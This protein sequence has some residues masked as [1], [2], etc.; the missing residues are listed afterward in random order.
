M[1]KVYTVT[2]SGLKHKK[3]KHPVVDETTRLKRTLKQ[4]KARDIRKKTK[5]RASARGKKSKR[6]KDF[7]DEHGRF[8]K[9][10]PGK[11][12][13][14]V[15][16]PGE[17]AL[18][19]SVRSIIEDVVRENKPSVHKAVLD[20]I[21]SGPSTAHLYLKL[22]VE[23]LDGRPVDTINVNSQ[24]KQDE[25]AAAKTSLGRKLDK[26]MKVILANKATPPPTEAAALATPPEIEASPEEPREESAE[27]TE[28][29]KR[30]A[31]ERDVREAALSRRW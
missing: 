11:P 22:A 30:A 17:R 24:Y 8:R 4:M 28:E 20:G 2:R 5:A 29:T 21:K 25:L 3:R 23:H 7:L 1:A 27:E 6:S 9:G 16:I 26:M 12:H 15:G 31:R 18:K 13:G 10:N 19:A 14:A